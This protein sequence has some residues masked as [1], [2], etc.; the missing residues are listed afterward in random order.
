MANNHSEFPLGKI[1]FILLAVGFVVIILGY[2]L[3]AGGGSNDPNVFNPDIFSFRRIVLAPIVIFL[4]F[5]IEVIAILYKPK[6]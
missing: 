6:K 4:G 2:V 1:N 3:M 5:V